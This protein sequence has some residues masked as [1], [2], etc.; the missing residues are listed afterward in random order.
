MADDDDRMRIAAHIVLEPQRAFEIEIVG[1]FVEQQQV[2]FCKENGGECHAH[3]P[4]AGKGRRRA[5][6]RLVVEAEAR[7]NGGSPRFRRMGPDIGEPRLDF[8]NPMRIGRR[9]RFEERA[10]RSLSAARTIEISESS[11]PGA[12]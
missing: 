10:A 4:T 8:G 2:R 3:A 1:R 11:V 7:Q 5:Q 12:S 9:L 6:L